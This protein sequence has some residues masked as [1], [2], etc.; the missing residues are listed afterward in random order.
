MGVETESGTNKI[1][2]ITEKIADWVSGN[3][4]GGWEIDEGSSGTVIFNFE[5]NEINLFHQWNTY[6]SVDT[7]VLDLDF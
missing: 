7:K 2:T 4:P 1:I 6:E 3:L 5:T